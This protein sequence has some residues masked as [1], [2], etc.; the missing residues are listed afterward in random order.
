MCNFLKKFIGLIYTHNLWQ[1]FFYFSIFCGFE[2]LANFPHF[3]PKEIIATMQKTHT[4]PSPLPQKNA[5]IKC[6][7]RNTK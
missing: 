3:F 6:F 7:V 2:S 4:P 5:D 1:A